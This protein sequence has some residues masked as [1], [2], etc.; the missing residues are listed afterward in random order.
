VCGAWALAGGQAAQDSPKTY[1]A[2]HL[3]IS[4]YLWASRCPERYKW[5]RES[6]L[7]RASMRALGTLTSRWDSV[8]SWLRHAGS[9]DQRIST[10]F[11]EWGSVI[12]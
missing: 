11:E 12:K 10:G 7:G 4:W 1:L 3:P 8:A 9:K 6:K 5:L 2:V